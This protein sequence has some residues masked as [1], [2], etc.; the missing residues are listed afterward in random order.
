M[1]QSRLTE[2]INMPK[3]KQLVNSRD[4]QFKKEEIFEIH[5][6]SRPYTLK[7]PCLFHPVTPQIYAN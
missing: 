3:I 7:N 6:G 2:I 1:K 4:S 5:G